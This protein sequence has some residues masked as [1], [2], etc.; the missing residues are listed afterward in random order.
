MPLTLSLGFSPC[1]NDTFIFDAMVHGKVDT[2][3]LA[4][5][6]FIAGVEELNQRAFNK[7]PD[8]TKLSF[9]AYAYL[10]DYYVLLNSGSALGSNCG[11]LLVTKK[12]YALEEVENLKIVIP[13]KYTTAN[14]LLSLAAPRAH[15]RTE[16][17][18]S[19]IEARVL[20]GEFDA[21][22]IIHENRFTYQDRGLK[23]IV[24]LGE[25]W[26]S[27]T[28]CPIPL[29]GIVVKRELPGEIKKKVERTLRRSVEH[30][31]L[32]P[33]SGMDFIK[34]H[35]Q[36]M[37]ADVIRKHIGLYVNEYTRDLGEEG[38]KAV[39]TLFQI[40]RDLGVT[41]KTHKD[42]F[43]NKPGAEKRKQ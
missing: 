27:R 18:F 24:D 6:P 3:G 17:L 41:P 42:L 8:I 12:D 5:D 37:D 33:E 16:A 30:A 1:P 38:R 25:Y 4:F 7:G 28:G 14:F 40:A 32:R 9:H 39:E 29:G 2:E 36:E 19:E 11:P 15:D 43:L 13:G 20:S 21:G 31:F 22:L 35:A 23:K 10:T 34:S 26:E